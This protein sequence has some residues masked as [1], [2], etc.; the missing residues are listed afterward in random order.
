[1]IG[2]PTGGCDIPSHF[3]LCAAAVQ[4]HRPDIRCTPVNIADGEAL[5]LGTV[6]ADF[7]GVMLPGSPLHINDRTSSVRRNPRERETIPE[8][9]ANLTMAPF[10]TPPGLKEI[11]CC[12]PVTGFNSSVQ[13]F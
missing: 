7:D 1:M 4:L 11:P 9:S 13:R 12:C 6:L 8:R 10:Q 5:P 3:S 2:S